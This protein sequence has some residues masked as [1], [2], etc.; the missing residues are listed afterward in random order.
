MA[1]IVKAAGLGSS[2]AAGDDASEAMR[3]AGLDAS[4]DDGDAKA[5]TAP[6]N[7]DAQRK[8]D[9]P[10]LDDGRPITSR[11]QAQRS[12]ALKAAGL[13]DS[14][15]DQD[16]A[17]S[18]DEVERSGALPADPFDDDFRAAVEDLPKPGMVQQ[19]TGPEEVW[20]HLHLLQS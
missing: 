9:D 16:R 17:R 6:P 13:E 8:A 14:D 1:D 3:A 19:L 20:C 2:D 7:E 18:P 12:D 11:P 4:E 5:S 15:S 10:N